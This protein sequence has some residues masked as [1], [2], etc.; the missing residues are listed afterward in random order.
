MPD[1]GDFV[2]TQHALALG[3][4]SGKSAKVLAC[5]MPRFTA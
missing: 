4:D 5:T 3:L 2:I 1:F